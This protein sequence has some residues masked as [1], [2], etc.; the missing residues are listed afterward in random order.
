MCATCLHVGGA[1]FPD[2]TNK[3]RVHISVPWAQGRTDDFESL[4][5][6]RRALSAI[7]FLQRRCRL[8]L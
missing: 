2:L 7:F 3:L 8:H 1:H 5:A 6:A 4:I